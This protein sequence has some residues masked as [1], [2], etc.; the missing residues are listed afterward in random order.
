MRTRTQRL[1]AR[2]G[3]V[4]RVLASGAAAATA[5]GLA[6]AAPGG[7]ASG[8][9][10]GPAT[11]DQ[12]DAPAAHTDLDPGSYAVTLLT[13][14]RVRLVVAE[15]QSLR[16]SLTPEVRADGSSAAL[17]WYTNDDGV[18]VV[19]SDV[20]P[21]LDSGLLDPKLF[22]VEYLAANGFTD[23]ATDALP[24][25]IE[26]PGESAGAGVLRAAGDDLGVSG[27]PLPSIGA[28][29]VEVARDDA[30][31]FWASVRQGWSDPPAG[32]RTM[33]AGQQ[34][35]RIWLDRVAHVVLDDSVPQIG[36]PQAWDAG[37][38]GAGVR[39]AVLDTGIDAGHP[40]VAGA[41]VAARRFIDGEGTVDGH[42]HGTHVAT[43]VAGDGAASGG[44]YTGVAPGADLVIG[45]VCDDNGSCPTSAIIAG[46]EWAA[47]E[48]DADV[49]SLSLGGCCT[50]GTDPLSQA[51]NQLSA[52]TGAL[53]VIAA[54]NDGSAPFTIGSP[55]AAD[56]ALTV[57]AVTKDG[58]MA[59]FSSRGPR[60][61][62]SAFKPEI[63]A[64]GVAIVAG[65]AAGTSMGTPVDDY[66]TAAQGTSM[67]TPHVSGAAALLAQQHPDWHGQ[68]LKGALVASAHDL[69][70]TGYEQGAGRVDIARAISQQVQVTP[71]VAD[72]R[73]VAYPP[74]GSPMTRTLTYTNPTT[75]PVTLGLVGSLAGLSGAEVP[76]G[77]LMLDTD[78]VTV[79]AG[80]EATVTVT[81]DQTALES[82]RY[83]GSVVASG[84][85]GLQLRTPVGISLG[86]QLHKL[87]VDLT[88]RTCDN[89]VHCVGDQ[90][91]FN[92]WML[93]A[94]RLGDVPGAQAAL[95]APAAGPVQVLL[96]GA[97]GGSTG[98]GDGYTY[99]VAA[100]G[101]S[102]SVDL[103][104]PE[105]QY[106]VRW[107][108]LWQDR[109]NRQQYPWLWAPDVVV[110]GTA[111]VAFDA[112][113]AVRVNH[114][115]P[116]PTGAD[117]LAASR[118]Y[119]RI[120]AD[121]RAIG[122]GSANAYGH[123]NYW[124]YPTGP[125]SS[126]SF[127]LSHQDVREAPQVTMTVAGAEP[128]LLSP[129]YSGYRPQG[130]PHFTVPVRFPEGTRTLP[131]VDVGT[132]SAA[133]YE[134][135]DV[136]GALV[137]VRNHRG[138]GF[139]TITVDR[140]RQALE[141]GAAGVLYNA[142]TCPVPVLM[143]SAPANED[144]PQIPYVSLSSADATLLSERLAAGPVQVTVTSH[145]V[146]P[147]V[148]I[149]RSYEEG[150]VPAAME[151][152]YPHDELLTVQA[153]YHGRADGWVSYDRFIH[154]PGT[155]FDMGQTYDFAAPVT[156]TEYLAP[157]GD[158]YRHERWVDTDE[159]GGMTYPITRSDV[160]D[161]PGRVTEHWNGDPWA[162]GAAGPRDDTML[163][164]GCREGDIFWPQV[165]LTGGDPGYTAGAVGWSIPASEDPDDPWA[166]LA[167]YRDGEPAPM[168]PFL[169]LL[170]SF[171]VPA[172]AGD[173]R[174][175][176][177]VSSGA[178]ASH[179]EWD[180]R[181]GPMAG[182]ESAPDGYD[183]VLAGLTRLGLPDPGL[184]CRA[185]PLIFLRY[186]GTDTDLS[187]RVAAP[188]VHRF[189]V[190][191]HRQPSADPRPE[192]AG[193][194]LWVSYDGGDRWHRADV[195]SL[196]DG[197][198]SVTVAH[199]PQ[200]Q[201][202]SD[203]VS[204]RA[205]AWD[206]DGNRIRQTVTDAYRLLERIPIECDGS[207]C[208]AQPS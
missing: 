48:Q 9:P 76:P 160:F 41:V 104:L 182:D 42:G 18:Y 77:T 15:D 199:P 164:A 12:V 109:K 188:G 155:T 50:D 35:E 121:G 84:D 151:Y 37:L 204:I 131:V 150:K 46:M 148:Y 56:A 118:A 6:L 58:Q 112:N 86:D 143:D 158:R 205:E 140:L 24:V 22:D 30:A 178:H 202:A 90:S 70:H 28:T 59:G 97:D 119:H 124:S 116:L 60:V 207:G 183:C 133:E 206:G 67:A 111:T 192:V 47:Q 108:P 139:C 107:E 157:V 201:R 10:S 79:P 53:F 45:K 198:Y 64:P 130:H 184:P 65:R 123:G 13:G 3:R 200:N 177:D 99:R 14:D 128:V 105:G 17:D 102:L 66:Y 44:T 29:A 68:Q 71:A 141:A 125:V 39:V 171:P 161:E 16:L 51:V 147:Y 134:G 170:P 62:D 94:W 135:L 54:G 110:P 40:D 181:S 1:A 175:V 80:G 127:V 169:G 189:E 11:T 33:A 159:I 7:P 136:T 69:G 176:M 25:I 19:P 2:P 115:T 144:K 172:G 117:G 73:F 173:Y 103:F 106:A 43:T 208:A 32:A 156:R 138:F 72:F 52:D 78:T 26:Y 23:D 82:G 196:G 49:V 101:G 4:R 190:A 31:G 88:A 27:R 194:K 126:G 83:T 38:D 75:A 180:F 142:E 137:L 197:H 63:A 187:N 5:L 120:L 129:I 113:E 93:K 153:N 185:E 114:H 91:S 163:C 21:H 92:Y 36:A 191:A 34:V 195:R 57:A 186:T 149:V 20:E 166:G 61:G 168:V 167:L 193:L 132:G 8:Q 87:T 152:H 162:P 55:G 95:S 154:V 81:L 165:H 85:A 74:E 145:A 98:T 96:D 122:F 174:L 100:D 146:S 179:T 89:D 203:S